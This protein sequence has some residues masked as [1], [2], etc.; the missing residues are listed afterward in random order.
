[1]GAYNNK[2]IQVLNLEKKEETEK[3][4]NPSS[5]GFYNSFQNLIGNPNLVL[6]KD[7]KALILINKTTH[8]AT[9]LVESVYEDDSLKNS[10][11]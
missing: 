10:M 3:I 11:V 1:M 8:I 9:L 2:E 7:K 6:V 5:N 4:P